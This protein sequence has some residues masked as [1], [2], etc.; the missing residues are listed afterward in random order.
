MNQPNPIDLITG[1]LHLLATGDIEHL[2]LWAQA[3]SLSASGGWR[4]L[5]LMILRA[6]G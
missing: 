4:N 2:K 3:V 6:M 1:L 5:A